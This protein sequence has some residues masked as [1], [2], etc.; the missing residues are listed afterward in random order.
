MFL[1]KPIRDELFLFF[2]LSFILY[3][4]S[5]PSMKILMLTPYLPWPLHSGGQIRTYNLLKNLAE[6]HDITLFSFIRDDGERAYIPKLESFCKKIQVFKRTK[7][8]WAIR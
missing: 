3:P 2:P 6:K 1:M 5:F 4:L 7:S 8:P